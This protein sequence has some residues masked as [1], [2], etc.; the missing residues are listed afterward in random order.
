VVMQGAGGFLGDR[1]GEAFATD[2][3]DG[4]QGMCPAAQKAAL[5]LG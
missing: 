1:I 5:I 3:D 4:F 2:L